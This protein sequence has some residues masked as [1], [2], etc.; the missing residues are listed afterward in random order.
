[1]MLLKILIGLAALALGI[2]LG[3]PG[4]E[5]A[6]GPRV[7]RWRI[8]QAPGRVGEHDEASLLELEE[9][10]GE[11]WGSSRKAKRH[12][13]LLN[14]MRKDPRGS[15][16]RRARRYFRTAAPTREGRSGRR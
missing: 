1:M 9:A 8:H 11:E 6:R 10:L 13:T 15:Q 7:G 2:Y 14:W 4:K 3:L 16:R 5:S 12:F